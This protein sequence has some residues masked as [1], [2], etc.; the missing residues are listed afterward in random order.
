MVGSR[1]HF[2]LSIMSRICGMN[3]WRGMGGGDIIGAVTGKIRHND[4][5]MI[6]PGR[7]GRHV[8]LPRLLLRLSLASRRH[9]HR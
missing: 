7:G 5:V 3:R 4:R 9:F 8:L 2:I 6:G 1:Y